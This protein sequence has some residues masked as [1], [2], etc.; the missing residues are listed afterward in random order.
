M[1]NQAEEESQVRD[2]VTTERLI[3]KRASGRA[4]VNK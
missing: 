1:Q 2:L 3:V 4:I